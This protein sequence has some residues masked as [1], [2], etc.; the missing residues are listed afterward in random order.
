MEKIAIL[1][2]HQFDR[3]QQPGF[4][5]NTVPAHLR[6]NHHA[7]SAP[8]KHNFYL[9]VL[10]TAGTGFHEIDFERF[11]VR[12]GSIFFLNP[13]QTHHWELSEDIDGWIFFHPESFY[14]LNFSQNTLQDYPFFYSVL[15]SPHLL[16]SEAETVDMATRMATIFDEYQHGR[17]WR[18][19]KIINLVDGL[20]IDLARTYLAAS[21]ETVHHAHMYSEKL[22]QLETLIDRLYRTEKSPAAYAA[23]MNISPKHLNRI[24]QQTVGK[25]TTQ[26]IT[27]RTLL[28]AKRLLSHGGMNLSEIALSLGY[29]EYAYFSRLFRKHTSQT[30][31]EFRAAYLSQK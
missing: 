12:R 8:H 6:E 10:F 16:L 20:Y 4:Y 3:S 24:V 28:E 1:D 17:P 18:T 22:R 2:I 14:S 15:N 5:A 7:I 13:G 29:D 23:K 31:S 21:P 26:L 30:P 9:T 25:T 19:R 27:E 11:E